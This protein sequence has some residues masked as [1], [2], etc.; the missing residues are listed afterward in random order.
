MHTWIFALVTALVVGLTAPAYAV[1][2]WNKSKKVV[3]FE[4]YKDGKKVGTSKEIAPDAFSPDVELPAD[5]IGQGL[6]VKV[7]EK[8]GQKLLKTI[9]NVGSLDGV[10]FEETGN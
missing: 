7:Y 3:Y 2:V 5:V 6:V 10:L 8:A 1:K 9:S 4:I